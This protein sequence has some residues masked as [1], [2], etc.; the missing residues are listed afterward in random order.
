MPPPDYDYDLFLSH[1]S[2]D[3]D[4]C[5]R[6]AKRV[7]GEG[8]RVW[9]DRWEL[10]FGDKLG[11][12]IND[13]IQRS[14]QMAV[15][16]TQSYFDP[17]K[18]WTQAE[19][20]SRQHAERPRQAAAPPP[21]WRENCPIP[22]LLADLLRIDFRADERFEANNC[23]QC[24]WIEPTLRAAPATARPRAAEHVEDHVEVKAHPLGRPPRAGL[25][26]L[27]GRG[28]VRWHCAVDNPY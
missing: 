25:A 21:D 3:A 23:Y 27:L 6:L 22:V 17:G 28:R 8:V 26:L 16:W 19:Q 9:F 13:G 20:W 2:E 12:R 14:R 5:E 24:V 15:V 1:A 7:R 4:W 10:Q 18:E 11:D